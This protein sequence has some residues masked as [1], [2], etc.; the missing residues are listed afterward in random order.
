MTDSPSSHT[1]HTVPVVESLVLSP[2]VDEPVRSA[3]LP[4]GITIEE[5]EDYTIK[6]VCGLDEDDGRTIFCE[7]C[8]TWQHVDCYYHNT[9]VPGTE[10]VHNC[11][12]CDPSKPVDAK[13]AADRQRKRKGLLDPD[14]RKLK[15]PPGKSHKKKLKHDQPDAHTNGWPY[16]RNE[17]GTHRNGYG[18]SPKDNTPSA[19]RPKTNHRATNSMFNQ[20]V[21][22]SASAH[23]SKRST[24]ASHTLQSPSKTPSNNTLN[25]YQNDSFS[26]DFLHLYDD[27]PGETT[28][29]GNTFSGLTVVNKMSVWSTDAEQLSEVTNGKTPE[30]VFMRCETGLDTHS[31][32]Q[33]QYKMDESVDYDGL[34]PRWTYLTVNAD[35]PEGSIIGELRGKVGLMEDY[36]QE[37]TNRWE[38]LRHPLPFVFFHPHLPIYIDTR[39]EGTICRYLRRSCSPNLT[40]K[41]FLAD[42]EY[43]FCYTSNQNLEANTELTIPWTTDEHVR[44]LLLEKENQIKLEGAADI[45]FTYVADWAS[46]VLADFGGCACHRG[47]DCSM[48]KFAR[49]TNAQCGDSENHQSRGKQHKRGRK[50]VANVYTN[51]TVR[52]GNSRSG[53]EAIKYQEDDEGDDSRSTSD[54]LR[55]K[56]NSRDMTPSVTADKNNVSGIEISDREKRKIAAL[57]KNFEQL[58]HDKLQ[59]A[60]KRKKRNSGGSTLNTPTAASGHASN[61]FGRSHADDKPDRKSVNQHNS[62]NPMPLTPAV[63]SKA[64]YTDTGTS[65]R[66]SESPTTYYTSSSTAVKNSNPFN[67]PSPRNNPNYTDSSMQTEPDDDDDDW[68][69]NQVALNIPRKPFISLTKRLLMRCHNDR[70]IMEEA[71]ATALQAKVS[72]E[73]V[74]YIPSTS[75]PVGTVL[76]QRESDGDV[77]MHDAGSTSLPPE[78]SSDSPVEKPRPPD[79][80]TPISTL[81]PSSSDPGPISKPPPVPQ[82]W[83]FPSLAD[84]KQPINGS[85]SVDLRLQLPP[86]ADTTSALT[87]PTIVGTPGSIGSTTAQSPSART[88]GLNSSLSVP[89]VPVRPSPVKKLTLGAYMSRLPKTIETSAAAAPPAIAPLPSVA[90]HSNPAPANPSN[91]VAEPAKDQPMIGSAIVETPQVEAG[92]PMEH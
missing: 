39:K 81:V 29:L 55:S 23:S 61:P 41:T 5:E 77:V 50:S 27:D 89:I 66:H 52:A 87:T 19:K 83:P 12:D 32:V 8:G 54:S 9:E 4:N 69:H 49:N 60:P 57:E 74:T 62:L 40:M 33:K 42:T 84:R 59:T 91:S 85:R 3:S 80:S 51:S 35:T 79:G 43:H 14:H 47:P 63:S 7:N 71:R 31:Q 90:A 2:N 34:H 38:Y 78:H 86:G 92:D 24:S 76:E 16:D 72:A 70:I 6:C 46:K 26:F 36:V 44:T 48:G 68:T 53:S 82:P 37:P 20:T 18:G 88:P 13:R 30:E 21:S 15:K 10:D 25:G 45:D 67:M 11:V 17:N 65:R 28:P 75:K 1:T 22:L 58:E 56:P 73:P 64:R